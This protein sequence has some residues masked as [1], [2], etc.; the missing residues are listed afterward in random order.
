MTNNKIKIFESQHIRSEWDVDA[1]KWWFSVL[2][3]IAVLTDQPDYEK[4]RNY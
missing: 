4:V 2:D 3:V 1:E